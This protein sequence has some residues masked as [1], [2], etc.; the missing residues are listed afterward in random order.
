[1]PMA[2][3]APAPLPRG[4]LLAGWVLAVA[5]PALLTGLLLLVGETDRWVPAAAVL[6]LLR[7]HR[8]YAR[9]AQI[10]ATHPVAQPMRIA[11]TSIVV[12]LVDTV[13]LAL[14]RALRFARTL[15][16]AQLR[17][18]HLVVDSAHAER[19]QQA[20]DQLET[21]ALPLELVDCPGRRLDRTAMVY[22]HRPVDRHPTA[23]VTVL[24]P[25]RTYGAVLGR[26]LHDKTAD[27]LAAAP[28]RS[29]GRGCGRRSG[30][31]RCWSG[32]RRLVCRS[33]TPRSRGPGS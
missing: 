5:A 31:V 4:R 2:P 19:L 6:G 12:V 21:R 22:T 25:R 3:R 23:Q 10:L 13:D 32:P 14:V 1:M 27:R 18:V 28:P 20:W 15:K 7:L 8:K 30:P 33:P 24:L 17:C 26:L 16:P 11:P 29:A 9:E